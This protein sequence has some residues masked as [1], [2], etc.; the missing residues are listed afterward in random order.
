MENGARRHSIGGLFDAGFSLR[1]A[2]EDR[3]IEYQ[4][5]EADGLVLCRAYVVRGGTEDCYIVGV[6][7]GKKAVAMKGT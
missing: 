6:G 1:G 2:R 5:V 4:C 3:Q 7:L